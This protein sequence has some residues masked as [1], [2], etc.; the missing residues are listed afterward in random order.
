MT[1]KVA[2]LV[3]ASVKDSVVAVTVRLTG[4]VVF[5]DPTGVIVIVCWP[6]GIAMLGTVEMVSVVVAL[7]VPLKLTLDGLKAQVA[8]VG[9]P[10]QLLVLKF[11][12]AGVEVPLVSGAIVMVVLVELPAETE[13]GIRPLFVSV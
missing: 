11:T 7:D 5:G 10:V 4:V 9:S 12:T 2:P 13:A 8:P 3:E 6:E 1:G